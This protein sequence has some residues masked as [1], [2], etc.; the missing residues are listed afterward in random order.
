VLAL[1]GDP[2]R[3]RDAGVGGADQTVVAERIVREVVARPEDLVAD[4][5]SAGVAVVAAIAA[6]AAILFVFCRVSARRAAACLP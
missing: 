3:V 5:Y 4:V 2:V 1:E 6:G